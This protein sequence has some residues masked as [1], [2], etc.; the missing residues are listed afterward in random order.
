VHTGDP[1]RPMMLFD[2][3]SDPAE[4]HNTA[5]EHP[6]VVKRLKRL[7]DQAAAQQP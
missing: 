5:A 4:Q 3:Q 7:Y 6:E 2:H 1:P